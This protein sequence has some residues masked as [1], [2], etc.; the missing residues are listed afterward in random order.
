[1]IDTDR[2]AER[3][4][5]VAALPVGVAG[6][7]IGAGDDPAAADVG[8][9]VVD[10]LDVQLDVTVGSHQPRSAAGNQPREHH[11]PEPKPSCRRYHHRADQP[12]PHPSGLSPTRLSPKHCCTSLGLCESVA[13]APGP[14]H[15]TSGRCTSVRGR[16]DGGS[17]V[18]AASRAAI[19]A[20]P[21]G[22]RDQTGLPSVQCSPPS[23]PD[24]FHLAVV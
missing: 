20:Q 19:F 9:R 23:P 21:R 16:R 5:A 24:C 17:P 14:T 1:M 4:G 22:Q 11:G 15:R 10:A 7:T 3:T 2:D 8:A 13:I 12:H 18:N 6:V